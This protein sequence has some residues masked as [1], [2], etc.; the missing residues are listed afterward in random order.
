MLLDRIRG[1]FATIRQAVCGTSCL[2]EP[3]QLPLLGDLRLETLVRVM[4]LG[5]GALTPLNVGPGRSR[6][7][8]V[9]TGS[10]VGPVTPQERRGRSLSPAGGGSVACHREFETNAAHVAK[11]CRGFFSLLPGRRVRNGRRAL[12]I[13][14]GRFP[15]R[16]L[17]EM[18]A[19]WTK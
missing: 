3:R 10:T 18:F 15:G 9:A 13:S 5:T 6:Q 2:L 14:G 4:D 7:S 12:H 8:R 17:A 19:I 1:Y 11:R 16:S